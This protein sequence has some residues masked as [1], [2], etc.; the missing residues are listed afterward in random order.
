MK[1][2]MAFLCALTMAVSMTACGGTSQTQTEEN[3]TS[4]ETTNE[5]T[6]AE[7]TVPNN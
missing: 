6:S 1:K 3:T 7:N 5:T 2:L 4:A